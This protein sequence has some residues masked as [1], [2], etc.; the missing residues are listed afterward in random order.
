MIAWSYFLYSFVYQF[1]LAFIAVII[2]NFFRQWSPQEWAL[3]FLIVFLIV[4]GVMAAISAVWFGIGGGIDLARMFRAQLCLT[5]CD[6]MDC[7]PL[8]SFLMGFSRQE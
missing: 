7:N 6:P 4:P 8:D 1:A 3:Y 2:W 5:L